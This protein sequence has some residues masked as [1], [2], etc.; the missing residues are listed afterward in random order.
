MRTSCILFALAVA[1]CGGHHHESGDDAGV[2]DLAMPLDLSA[3]TAS[4]DMTHAADDAAAVDAFV[5]D[6][7]APD[8]L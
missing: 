1:G 2:P 8:L 4:A 6:L 5:V 3:G 7:L